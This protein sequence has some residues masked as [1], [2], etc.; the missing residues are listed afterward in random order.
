MIFQELLKNGWIEQT[1]NYTNGERSIFLYKNLVTLTNYFLIITWDLR[2]RVPCW[3]ILLSDLTQSY[4]VSNMSIQYTGDE[5]VNFQ[6]YIL[7]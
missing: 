2:V 5:Y 6:E 1:N 7:D 4:K 3:Y